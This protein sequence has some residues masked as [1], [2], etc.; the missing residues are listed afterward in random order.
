MSLPCPL[1]NKALK[2]TRY[3]G[4]KVGLC[5][6]CNG[7]FMGRKNLRN[8]EESHEISVPMESG[9]GSGI[10]VEGVKKCPKCKL[11]M[12]LK[13]YGELGAAE[14]DYCQGCGG[15]WL[16]PGELERI[17]LY[18][19]AVHDSKLPTTTPEKPS[20]ACPRCGV[21]QPESDEC[22]SCGIIFA[23]FQA[24]QSENEISQQKVA[25]ASASLEQKL[26]N[27]RSFE[28]DQKY[29]LTEA[30]FSFERK[31]E[32]SIT[33][34]PENAVQGKWHIEELNASGL[35]I[36]GRNLFGLLYTFTMELTD[37]QGKI[38]FRIY[39]KARL[40]FH[41]VDV[42]DETGLQ[43]GRISRRFSYF[44]RVVS[45]KNMKNTEMLRLVGPLLKPWTFYL[46]NGRSK[47]GVISKKWSGLLKEAYTDADKFSLHFNTPLDPER[48]RL[49]LAALM[50]IDSLY[51]EGKKGFLGHLF[52]APG[53]Q[54]LAALVSL[55]V[56]ASLYPG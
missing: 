35:S 47:V 25:S 49:A 17:Q 1:C 11:N 8:I 33:I 45:A 6:D 56:F 22:S 27:I 12:Q 26:G 53:L 46:Y 18:Y 36:L 19:R 54:L 39:R 50:L 48:K 43:R 16:D 55:A 21:A 51:F 2:I 9:S 31:N 7:F 34:R 41:S 10:N 20:F 32:Y 37:E 15:I 4:E 24:R 42:H 28:V 29:H 44:N 23:R 52:S 40:Y 14:V 38:I 30:I 13:S 5:T 3:E